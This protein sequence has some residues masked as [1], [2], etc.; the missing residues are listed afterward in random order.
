MIVKEFIEMFR[1]EVRKLYSE[2]VIDKFNLKN[3]AHTFLINVAMYNTIKSYNKKFLQDFQ[4]I[5]EEGKGGKTRSDFHIIKKD[6]NREVKL[7]IEHE[8]S[9]SKKNK[10][11]PY[12]QIDY[13]YNKLKELIES[14]KTKSGLLICYLD[15]EDYDKDFKECIKPKKENKIY[16][17]KI[18]L[19][20]GTKKDHNDFSDSKEYKECHLSK[21]IFLVFV[22]GEPGQ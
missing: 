16:R 11:E 12:G 4:I 13:C 19:L 9:R 15:K 5:P 22:P 6:K 17:N 7:A 3:Y 2:G 14:K 18:H 8:H 1:E 20:I 10:N 21:L